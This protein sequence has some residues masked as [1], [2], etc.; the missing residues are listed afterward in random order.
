[1]K[2]LSNSYQAYERQAFRG[3]MDDAYGKTSK[4]TNVNGPLR[5]P[6]GDLL[7]QIGQKLNRC[8]VVGK[9]TAWSP[10]TGSKP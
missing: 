1:M 3:E 7:N 6:F 5:A 8:R 10:L 4:R 2:F 9:P